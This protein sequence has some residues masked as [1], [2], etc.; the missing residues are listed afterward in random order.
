MPFRIRPL[1]FCQIDKY[2]SQGDLHTEEQL[3]KS[4][5]SWSK[6]CSKQIP[7]VPM[8]LKISVLGRSHEQQVNGNCLVKIMQH[9]LL[10]YDGLMLPCPLS[11]I[12]GWLWFSFWVMY[13]SKEH[14]ILHVLTDTQS[15]WHQASNNL[16]L[17]FSF[18]ASQ[19][20]SD[21]WRANGKSGSIF[22]CK[23]LPR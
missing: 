17:G 21:S 7:G 5:P 6:L 8:H 3:N 4:I 15:S 20:Q 11:Q 9:K 19:M 14:I 10:L 13:P 22:H 2:F 12:L 23:S 1:C 16:L 18:V